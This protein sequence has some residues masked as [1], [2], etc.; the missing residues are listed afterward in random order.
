MRMRPGTV[1]TTALLAAA[2]AGCT[3]APALAPTPAAPTSTAV[4]TPPS[5]AAAIAPAPS[6]V[7]IAATTEAPPLSQ[8]ILGS[9]EPGDDAQFGTLVTELSLRFPGQ[10]IEGEWRAD[11]VPQA[12][13]VLLGP[14]PEEVRQLLEAAPLSVEVVTTAGPSL[15]ESNAAIARV[16]ELLKEHDAGMSAGGGYDQHE[17]RYSIDYTAASEIDREAVSAALDGAA[18]RLTYLGTQP[19]GGPQAEAL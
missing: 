17:Q 14:V 10:Y 18:V 5:A 1:L 12:R 4:A 11:E 6:T 15:E 13:V 3:A 9:A 2:L 16:F 19:A 7:D 8:E